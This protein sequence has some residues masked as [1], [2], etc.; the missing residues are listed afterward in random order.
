MLSLENHPYFRVCYLLSTVSDFSW[1][2]SKHH[3]FCVPFPFPHSCQEYIL[4]DLGFLRIFCI[5]RRFCKLHIARSS[6]RAPSHHSWFIPEICPSAQEIAVFTPQ[7]LACL[8]FPR[9]VI[10]FKNSMSSSCYPTRGH[11]TPNKISL[12]NIS[13]HLRLNGPQLQWIHL[14]PSLV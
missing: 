2:Y 13:R 8:I 7:F 4:I 14:I 6:V 10:D 11:T 1:L 9:L 12:P 3:W 5:L